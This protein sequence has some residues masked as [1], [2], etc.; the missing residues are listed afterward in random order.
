MGQ[1][2]NFRMFSSE[3]NDERVSSPKKSS[4]P[5]LPIYAA[6]R[7]VPGLVL[8]LQPSKLFFF[9]EYNSYIFSFITFIIH[10]DIS[11]GRWGS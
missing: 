4:S 5:C 7:L 2:T 3:T 11:W 8:T 6:G 9:L 1:L 10:L